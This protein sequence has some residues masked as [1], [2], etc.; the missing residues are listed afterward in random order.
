[1]SILYIAE[2]G[3]NHN[4]DVNLAKEMADA[5]IESGA[6]FVKFQIYKTD[7][8]ISKKNIYFDEFKSEE[9]TYENFTELKKYTEK[10]GGK[11]L[12]TP[13]DEESLGFLIKQQVDKVKIS[14]GDCNNYQLLE[15]AID[16]GLELIIS[17]GGVEIEEID[18]I[19]EFLDSHDANYS[20]LHCIINYP[21]EF[22]ELNLNFIQTLKRRYS[23]PVGYSDHSLGIEAV[24]AAIALGAEIIEKHFT[25]DNHLPGGDNEMSILPGELARLIKEGNNISQSLGN[26]VRELS[27]NEKNNK[28]LISRKFTAVN[29]IGAGERIKK[30]DIILLRTNETE[31][32][33]CSQE[34]NLILN[35]KVA[36]NI[37]SGDI[38][39]ETDLLSF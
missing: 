15:K 13:F 19:V 22:S 4:G 32:G 21:A 23:C 33:F 27:I 31:I 5:A 2:I 38:I 3:N 25:I 39:K 36:F 29:D 34:I 24:L 14:S 7:K 28:T 10:K 12:A 20:L 26:G 1:M 8:F 35:R 6:D 17:I 30:D 9:L 16:S 37:Q 11:F 18:E